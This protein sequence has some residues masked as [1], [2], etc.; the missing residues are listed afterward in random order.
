MKTP[1]LKERGDELLNSSKTVSATEKTDLAINIYN[2]MK[3]NPHISKMP[4]NMSSLD[5]KEK[6]SGGGTFRN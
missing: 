4:N 5:R 3:V 6:E 2:S 1:T